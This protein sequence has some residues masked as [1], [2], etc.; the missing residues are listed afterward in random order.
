MKSIIIIA[1]IYV[2]CAV[3]MMGGCIEADDPVETVNQPVGGELLDEM[4]DNHVEVEDIKAQAQANFPLTAEFDF[5]EK[6]FTLEH[7]DS[8]VVV[9]KV[10]G[11]E[12]SKKSAFHEVQGDGFRKYKLCSKGTNNGDLLT[13]YQGGRATLE[14]VGSGEALVIEGSWH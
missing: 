10:D 14:K 4:K 2:I 6:S 13:L 9:T 11:Y 5:R 7:D 8:G 12:G 1:T 3:T